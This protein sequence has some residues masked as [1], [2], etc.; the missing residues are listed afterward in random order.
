MC[1]E[2]PHVRNSEVCPICGLYKARRLRMCWLCWHECKSNTNLFAEYEGLLDAEE[3]VL[4]KL[5]V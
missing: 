4:A 5:E 1:E 2:H 3:A